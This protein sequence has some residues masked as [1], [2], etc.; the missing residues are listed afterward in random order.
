[1]YLDEDDIYGN[2]LFMSFD[3]HLHCFQANWIVSVI[4]VYSRANRVGQM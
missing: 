1:M 2:L 4:K 3:L